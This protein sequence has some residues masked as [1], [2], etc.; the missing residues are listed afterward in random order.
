MLLIYLKNYYIVLYVMNYSF[1]IMI[2]I[3][4]YMEFNIARCKKVFDTKC[5]GKGILSVHVHLPGTVKI[6]IS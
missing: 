2:L 1:Q 5:E 3:C 6:G 4:V